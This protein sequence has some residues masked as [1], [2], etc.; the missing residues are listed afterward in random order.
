[1]TI[2]LQKFTTH[3][4]NAARVLFK[5]WIF[6][7]VLPLKMTSKKIICVWLRF[8]YRNV[9][10]VFDKKNFCSS[11]NSTST[12]TVSTL[13]SLYPSWPK[14]KNIFIFPFLKQ[15][16]FPD[17]NRNS[18]LFKR[19]GGSKNCSRSYLVHIHI[20]FLPSQLQF[21][22]PIEKTMCR[23][24]VIFLLKYCFS[25]QSALVIFKILC[26]IQIDRT[27]LEYLMLQ[28]AYKYLN[29]LRL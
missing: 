16:L 15:L 19:R 28:F 22:Y 29:L 18:R 4:E 2:H 9:E 23:L 7:F 13:Q 21:K 10:A 11:Y 3:K 14:R 27:D 12:W 17:L 1:M 25:Y 20:H 26:A 5:K 24:E 6:M 8:W